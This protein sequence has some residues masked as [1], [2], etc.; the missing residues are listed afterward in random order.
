MDCWTI[1]RKPWLEAFRAG[2]K[3][4]QLLTVPDFVQFWA[5]SQLYSSI[6]KDRFESNWSCQLQ[7]L[8][9]NISI[10]SF[11]HSHTY[12][13]IYTIYIVVRRVVLMCVH[14]GMNTN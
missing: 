12:Y 7:K 8:T 2:Q 1:G 14:V 5:M 6:K 9:L 13:Y 10:F 3:S 4:V 11:K